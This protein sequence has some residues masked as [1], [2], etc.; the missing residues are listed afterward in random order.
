[1]SRYGSFRKSLSKSLA[2]DASEHD[3]QSAFV[4]MLAQTGRPEIEVSFAIPN[5]GKRSFAVAAMLKAEGFK[6]GM[7]DWCLPVARQGYNCLWI[8][9]KRPRCKPTQEQARIHELL[10]LHGGK[11]LV[12][13]SA[14]AAVD[15][16][17]DY[18]SVPQSTP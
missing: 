2:G 18:L 8:E 17:I 13:T 6:T 7:P 10:I 3:I 4:K 9:F 14:L 12:C 15:A 16:V 1:M 11:V 5:A